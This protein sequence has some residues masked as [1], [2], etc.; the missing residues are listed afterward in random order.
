MST[1]TEAETLPTETAELDKGRGGNKIIDS[2]IHNQVLPTPDI[3]CRYLPEKWRRYF[4][5]FG[6]RNKNEIAYFATRPRAF[7]ARG[8]SLPP[9]GL[10]PGGDLDFLRE[11]LLDYWN[12]ECGILNPV[13]Q[14]TLGDQ[15]AEY[16]NALA[17]AVNDYTLAE[18]LEQ[19]SRLYAS[20]CVGQEDAELAAEEID[21]LGDHPRFVQVL[22]NARTREPLG[23]RKYWKLYE[24]AVRHDLPILIHVGGIG[25]NAIT[26]V[27]WPS[28]YFEDHAGYV[29]AFHAQVISMVC[30][31]VF[32][33]FPT[34]KVVLAEGGFAW[35][36]PLMWRMDNSVRQLRDEVPHLRRDPSDYIRDHIWFTTQPIEEP[37][38]PEYFTQVLNALDMDSKL[39]FSSDYPHWDFDAP[40]KALPR[41]V[42]PD[43]RARIM[44]EN[45]R[46]LYGFPAKDGQ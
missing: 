33:R 1:R 13:D 46:A 22:L 25:G 17:R 7:A 16:S 40:D 34:L 9:S 38:K 26:G 44:S 3:L 29:Q 8:D 42:G 20:I 36:P 31:G 43:L 11:Q 2:D 21:R 6:L 35:V 45:A 4:E 37:E 19:E 18:W 5:T 12:I 30:E 14:L 24:A 32:E 10:P 41:S 27:G 23:N 15:P 28:Y 39:L